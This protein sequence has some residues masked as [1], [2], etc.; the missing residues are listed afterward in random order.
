MLA[1]CRCLSDICPV[2]ERNLEVEITAR[3][4]YKQFVH[5]SKDEL[6]ARE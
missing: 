3:P 5:P 2:M 4:P 6:H 1:V